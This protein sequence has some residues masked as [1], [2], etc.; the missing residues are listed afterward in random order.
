MDKNPTPEQAVSVV[1][2]SALLKDPLVAVGFIQGK[3]PVKGG[4][5]EQPSSLGTTCRDQGQS[6]LLLV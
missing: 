6:H 4:R 5:R 1:L 2:S 3:P